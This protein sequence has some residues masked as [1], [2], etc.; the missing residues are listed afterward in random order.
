[1]DNS[2]W[3]R[4]GD[5]EPTRWGATREAVRLLYEI[6]LQA[7][8][9]NSIGIL[10]MAGDRP[11]LL[12]TP[13]ADEIRLLAIIEDLKISMVGV[14][15]GGEK[16][17]LAVSIGIS[18]LALKNRQNRNQR[19]RIVAII[20][21][22]ISEDILQLQKLGQQLKKNAIAIDAINFCV[23]ENKEKLQALIDAAN[24]HSNS[25]FRHVSISEKSVGDI[26]IALAMSCNEEESL[27]Q[28]V[29]SE[30]VVDPELAEAVRMAVKLQRRRRRYEYR[31]EL[32]KNGSTRV[33]IRMRR[34][35]NKDKSGRQPKNAR[36]TQAQK[37]NKDHDQKE[38]KQ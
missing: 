16:I 35:K 14:I 18:Q 6:K 27:A 38:S 15:L 25:H 1:M 22:P 36:E 9:E 31:E 17:D 29:L 8:S 12:A 30:P 21:S 23:E 3:G 28:V 33:V 2:E 26:M 13:C 20:Y 4:N 7:N 34:R 10:T 37:N 19:Q 11:D 24:N 5:F 32:G